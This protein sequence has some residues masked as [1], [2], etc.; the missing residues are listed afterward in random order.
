M[1]VNLARGARHITEANRRGSTSK[2]VGANGEINAD[3]KNDLLRQFAEMASA[4]ANGEMFTDVS[5]N[6]PEIAHEDTQAELA[7][8]YAGS[9]DEWNEIGSGLA[10][11]LDER[12]EREGFMRSILDRAEVAE[13]SIPRIRIHTPNVRAVIARGVA[14][15]WAQFVRDKY[16]MT[17]EF[18]VSA[19]LRVRQLDMHQGSSNI[20]EDKYY[21]ALEQI[22]VKE[23]TVVYSLMKSTVGLHNA[24]SYWSGDFTPAL[25]QAMRYSVSR[26]RLPTANFLFAGDILNDFVAASGFS[27]WFDPVSKYE[28]VQTGR[29]GQLLGM[30]LITDGFRE[31]TLK[32]LEEGECFVTSTPNYT[33]AYTDRGPV[34]STPVDSYPDGVAARGFYLV[35]HISAALSN[36]KAVAYGKRQ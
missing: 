12:M 9:R 6:N 10:A 22:F 20:L 1:K 5:G 4:I 18:D 8:A 21:E 3:N 33:G 32:V 17:D 14:Q 27:T 28:I 23:D 31:P 16:I 29:I 35:E 36:A 13:G 19:N 7:S 15:N 2:L 34:Q 25:M 30:N 24:A 11:E 26:W